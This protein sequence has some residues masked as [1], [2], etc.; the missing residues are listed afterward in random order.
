MAAQAAI[1][2]MTDEQLEKH[3]FGVLSQEL[4]LLGYARFL[5]L[6]GSNRGDYTTDRITWLDGIAV[7]DTMNQTGE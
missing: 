1:A 6:Y 3:A 7:S 4:G 2:Q 5:R